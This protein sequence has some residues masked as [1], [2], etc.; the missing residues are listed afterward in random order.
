M[1]SSIRSKKMNLNP[2]STAL[3]LLTLL[4]CILENGVQCFP[5]PSYHTGSHHPQPQLPQ[6]A[7]L[8]YTPTYYGG[9][10]EDDLPFGRKFKNWTPE[11][12]QRF[13]E[14]INDM[15]P[16]M[17]NAIFKYEKILAGIETADHPIEILR[18]VKRQRTPKVKRAVGGKSV[19]TEEK[20]K[21]DM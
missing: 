3:V 4:H 12:Q 11:I 17:A 16:E 9:P 20:K 8:P 21:T 18:R 14:R 19:I 15:I 10:N 7:K 2:S 13:L 6:E 1:K 5:R